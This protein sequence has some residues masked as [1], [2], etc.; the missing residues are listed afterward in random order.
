[1]HIACAEPTKSK[2][3]TK[4]KGLIP[5]ALHAH[6]L[7]ITFTTCSAQRPHN[8]AI[9]FTKWAFLPRWGLNSALFFFFFA[10]C[11]PTFLK[12]QW[13]NI[14]CIC[15]KENYCDCHNIKDRER[16]R[17][18]LWMLLLCVSLRAIPQRLFSQRVSRIVHLGHYNWQWENRHLHV[19]YICVCLLSCLSF[20]F[21]WEVG[22]L[23][24]LINPKWRANLKNWQPLTSIGRV[25]HS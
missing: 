8:A 10:I 23:N 12:M 15:N 22:P 11:P 24:F 16:T 17:K 13:H 7:C 14:N 5:T 2:L 4:I 19:R 21:I 18:E 9:T 3:E 6:S 1:M 25:H 20:P